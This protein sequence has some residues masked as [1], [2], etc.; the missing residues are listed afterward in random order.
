MAN[1]LG[2]LADLA[3]EPRKFPEVA[4]QS[5][6]EQGAVHMPVNFWAALMKS[7]AAHQIPL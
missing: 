7:R 1:I 2:T 5:A 4:S 3:A 6:R